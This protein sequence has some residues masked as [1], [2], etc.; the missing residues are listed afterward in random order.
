MEPERYFYDF[1]PIHLNGLND[2]LSR[3]GSCSR[4]RAHQAQR[5]WG[6]PV[7]SVLGKTMSADIYLSVGD[8][9]AAPEKEFP[10][11]LMHVSRE[12]QLDFLCALCYVVLTDQVVYSHFRS[13]YQEFQAMT[14]YPKMDESI[15]W[16]R[17]MMMANPYE[18]F[19][20]DV[21]ASRSIDRLMALKLFDQWAAFLVGDL[22]KFFSTQQL[23]VATWGNVRQAMLKDV[24]CIAGM[25][26]NSVRHH[27]LG[28]GASGTK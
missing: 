25:F 5:F 19:G 22:E 24:G 2:S 14:R 9:I 7:V 4:M 26:D 11:H 23:G 21:L 18:V 20:V 3:Q 13:A 10:D 17:T 1:W 16:A 15:G 8:L 12:L 27:L 28:A 6:A